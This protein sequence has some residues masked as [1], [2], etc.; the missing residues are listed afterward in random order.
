MVETEWKYLIGV[1]KT[2]KP[3]LEDTIHNYLD[4]DILRNA[5]HFL[6]FLKENGMTPKW[7]ATQTWHYKYKGKLIF[8]I[9]LHGSVRT[10]KVRTR[11]WHISSFHEH[12][13]KYLEDFMQFDDN[14]ENK[15][16]SISRCANCGTCSPGIDVRI[17]GKT[18]NSV[19]RLEI[20][21]PDVEAIKVAKKLV[22]ANKNAL[23]K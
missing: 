12:D 8:T 5:L 19:C 10:W 4:G 1:Q 2:T 18:Y 20:I 11:S 14:N 15:W 16:L 23:P 6:S 21:N 9:R 13:V 3:N 17:L 7:S 22:L